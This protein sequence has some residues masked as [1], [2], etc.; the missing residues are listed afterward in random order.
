MALYQTLGN[1]TCR[2]SW[3]CCFQVPVSPSLPVL[4][5]PLTL[6]WLPGVDTVVWEG[7]G[8]QGRAKVCAIPFHE[9]GNA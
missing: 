5:A 7:V 9:A 8:A 2:T 4:D 6:S 1:L 3:V